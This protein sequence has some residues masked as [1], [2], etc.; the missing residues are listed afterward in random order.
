MKQLEKYLK[1]H[2]HEFTILSLNVQ[3]IRA[4]FDQ[5][6]VILCT[7][8]NEGLY[9]SII[10]FQET[11]LAENDDVTPFLLPGY[12]LSHQYKSCSE[13]GGLLTY[14]RND[15]S[16][17]ILDMNIN[18]LSWEGLFVDVFGEQLNKQIHVGNIYLLPKN[19]NNNQ[20]IELF[21]EE[22]SPIVDRIGKTMSHGIMVGDFNINLMQI[23]G[24]EKFGD[25]FGLMCANG[26]LPKITFPT[27]FAQKSCSLIDQMFC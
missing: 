26:F 19:N 18:S 2:K 21:I 4:K 9:F 20:S 15:F 10:R 24:R 17:K 1:D 22:F 5:L 12:S 14:I 6:S 8:Y 16:Y 27:R 11:W 23:Q 13:H 3:S 7:L 25:F